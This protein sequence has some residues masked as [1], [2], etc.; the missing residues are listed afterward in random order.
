[1]KVDKSKYCVI[2]KDMEMIIILDVL[3]GKVRRTDPNNT[4]GPQTRNYVYAEF[5]RGCVIKVIS[6]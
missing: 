6:D 2:Y 3:F 1:M 5:F 4:C